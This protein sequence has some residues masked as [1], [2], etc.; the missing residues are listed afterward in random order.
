MQNGF[1]R[2]GG[3]GGVQ[4][5]DGHSSVSCAVVLTGGGSRGPLLTHSGG[6]VGLSI[7]LAS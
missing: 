1:S 2:K 5:S 4:L 7:V 3:N 6:V